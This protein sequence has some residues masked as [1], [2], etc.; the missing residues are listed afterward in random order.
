[1]A[2]AAAA[3]VAATGAAN[4][5]G[6]KKGGLTAALFYRSSG[7]RP[8][9]QSESIIEKI[10]NRIGHRSIDGYRSST[11]D[12]RPSRCRDKSI[13]SITDHRSPIIDYQ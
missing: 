8:I 9:D 7:N 11:I 1:V 6:N 5:G 10:G 4:H 13:R 3:A 2:G 12:N